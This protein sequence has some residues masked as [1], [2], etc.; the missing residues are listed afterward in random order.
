MQVLVVLVL[1]VYKVRKWPDFDDDFAS[2]PSKL[3]IK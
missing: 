1:V 3:K 2:V